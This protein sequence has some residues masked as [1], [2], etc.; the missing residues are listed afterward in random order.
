MINKTI[1]EEL[2]RINENFD[3]FSQGIE[4]ELALDKVKE[5]YNNFVSYTGIA[6]ARVAGNPDT[7]ICIG[8]P[9]ALIQYVTVR[10]QKT[11]KENIRDYKVTKDTIKGLKTFSPNYAAQ[12][13][14]VLKQ[15]NEMD[16]NSITTLAIKPLSYQIPEVV[17]RPYY[18]NVG[19]RSI[20]L[21]DPYTAVG[22]LYYREGK[23]GVTESFTAFDDAVSF[24]EED[25]RREEIN[26]YFNKIL[27]IKR[28]AIPKDIH[29]PTIDES[30]VIITQFTQIL[31]RRYVRFRLTGRKA[32]I[33]DVVRSLGDINH[34]EIT[35]T[36]LS[37]FF[38]LDDN[39]IT[40]IICAVDLNEET[41]APML[42]VVDG[43]FPGYE[44]EHSATILSL[45]KSIY[46]IY[47]Y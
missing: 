41:G 14:A 25:Q 37:G 45:L 15:L 42:I 31:M 2:K 47:I 46:E 32:D 28:N 3:E 5:Y 27:D 29:L 34:W 1:F 20:E 40:Q 19:L 23:D 17:D 10:L 36:N 4:D 43:I 26:Y 16:P 13:R 22:L 33:L 21:L 44:K 18:Q 39:D 30:K 24:T 11:F 8:K 7:F 35:P 9:N 38:S 6:Y 12:E